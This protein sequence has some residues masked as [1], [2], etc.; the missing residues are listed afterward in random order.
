MKTETI[1]EAIGN[2][3]GTA[4]ADVVC[5]ALDRLG[6]VGR[7]AGGEISRVRMDYNEINLEEGLAWFDND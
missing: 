7:D 5:A 2:L 3:T 6:E 4:L 1:I